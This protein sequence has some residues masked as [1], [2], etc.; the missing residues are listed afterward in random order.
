METIAKE[1]LDRIET[2]RDKARNRLVLTHNG[3]DDHECA[4]E[5]WR[6][7]FGEQIPSLRLWIM[8]NDTRSSERIITRRCEEQKQWYFGY[9]ISQVLCSH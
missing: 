6:Q 7:I 2:A 1:V 9:V 8:H 3:R 4:I 5:V